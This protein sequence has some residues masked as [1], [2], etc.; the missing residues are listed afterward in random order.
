MLS[1]KLVLWCATF[2][3]SVAKI[4]RNIKRKHRLHRN[5][6]HLLYLLTCLGCLYT[7][8][9]LTICC[10]IFIFAL[11]CYFK[12]TCLPL[13]IAVTIRRLMLLQQPP[14]HFQK[15]DKCN[16][17]ANLPES[18]TGVLIINSYS[19]TYPFVL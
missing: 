12:C 18:N 14:A 7:V 15:Q 13:L 2:L 10:V 3:A 4:F 5:I 8:L 11:I 19:L 6:Y 17:G 9:Y 16:A 1:F